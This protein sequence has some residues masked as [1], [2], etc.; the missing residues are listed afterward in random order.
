MQ[1]ST[2]KYASVQDTFEALIKRYNLDSYSKLAE[3]IDVPYQTLMA[4]KKRNSIGD[5]T[6]FIDKCIGISLD[7]VRT[8][9]GDMFAPAPEEWQTQFIQK[10]GR[11]IDE[12][13]E[14]DE[15]IR[16]PRYEVQAS[17]GG[18]AVI[19][20]EQIVDYLSFRTDWLKSAKGISPKNLLLISV[21]GDSME[22]T[23]ANGDLIVVDTTEGRFKSDAIY[24][25][26]QGDRLWVKRLHYKL[27]GTVLVK[28][29]NA[30]KYEP[31][32]FKG[33]QLESLRII[34]RVVWRGG[35]L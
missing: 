3:F 2:K 16:L 19:T 27:D 20:S 17:A 7:W 28:S 4:W 15:Y 8:G 31:E 11:R 13:N 6:V 22:P 14:V 33:D 21:S 1:L 9:E 25:L 12:V 30:S 24:V 32:L 35:D 10:K 5:R 23:L 34:G 29:D 26:Q 18:G